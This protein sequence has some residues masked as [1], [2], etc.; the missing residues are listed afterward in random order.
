[1]GEFPTTKSEHRRRLTAAYFVGFFLAAVAAQHR[2][3][4]ALEDLLSD[5][6][7]DSGSVIDLSLSPNSG[8]F[9][10]PFAAVL[11]A[12]CPAC[13]DHDF[14]AAST[15]VFVLSDPS[16]GLA[17]LSPVPLPRIP[18]PGSSAPASRSPPAAT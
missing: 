16:K 6:P 13:F 2:H 12:P 3:A 15:S 14:V 11:D 5:G 18:E 17:R 10:A 8:T 7:S 1:V 9:L 4:N